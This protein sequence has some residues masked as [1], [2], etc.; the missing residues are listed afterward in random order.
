M[1]VEEAHEGLVESLV[2][3]LGEGL[4]RV[5]EGGHVGHLPPEVE[6]LIVDGGEDLVRI[7]SIDGVVLDRGRVFHHGFRGLA[8]V[9]EGVHR[10]VDAKG[11]RAGL[12]IVLRVSHVLF[13]EGVGVAASLDL[14]LELF[15]RL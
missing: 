6:G 1:S 10:A 11:G 9:E 2:G 4:P 15:D 8:E 13:E 12:S 14:G 7:V 3:H 5:E